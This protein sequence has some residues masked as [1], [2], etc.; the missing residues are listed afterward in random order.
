MV[1]APLL[2]RPYLARLGR[3]DLF[4]IMTAGMATIAGTMLVLY[5]GFLGGVMPLF[6]SKPVP[7]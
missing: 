1:E 5:A 2:V 4:L 7:L 3:G 6:G